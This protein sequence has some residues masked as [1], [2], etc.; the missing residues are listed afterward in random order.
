M[1]A[2]AH[3]ILRST[4][5][6]S[7]SSFPWAAFPSPAFSFFLHIWMLNLS[8]NVCVLFSVIFCFGFGCLSVHL[9]V[10]LSACLSVCVF[11]CN[12]SI[13]VRQETYLPGE[14][15]SVSALRSGFGLTM[16]FLHPACTLSW[17]VCFSCAPPYTLYTLPPLSPPPPPACTY[18]FPS[19]KQADYGAQ[20]KRCMYSYSPLMFALAHCYNVLSAAICEAC[21]CVCV[22]VCVCAW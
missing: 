9:S 1:H 12:I 19:K 4:R 16:P 18:S 15:I 10:R 20:S 6:I 5:I 8:W 7:S 14:C 21:V 3:T 13:T 22:A 17:Y 11:F 2:T